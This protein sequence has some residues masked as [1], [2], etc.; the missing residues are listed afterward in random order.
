MHFEK[1]MEFELMGPIPLAVHVLLQLG[2]SMKKK[3]QTKIFE[4]TIIYS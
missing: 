4:C 2:I 3:S 1:M